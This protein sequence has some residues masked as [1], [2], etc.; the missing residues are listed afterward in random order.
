MHPKVNVLA[1]QLPREQHTGTERNFSG[2]TASIE[3]VTASKQDVLQV[4]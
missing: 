3:V 1:K 4:G 2:E